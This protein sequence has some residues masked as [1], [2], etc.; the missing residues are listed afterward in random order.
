MTQ[1]APDWMPDAIPTELGWQDPRTGEIILGISGL[2]LTPPE[3]EP[4]VEEQP[5]AADTPVTE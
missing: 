4:V 5:V 2:D 1:R 3:E